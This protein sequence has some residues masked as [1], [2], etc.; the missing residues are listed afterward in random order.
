[1]QTFNKFEAPLYFGTKFVKLW[2]IKKKIIIIS[3]NYFMLK[4]NNIKLETKFFNCVLVSWKEKAY[5]HIHTKQKKAR[6]HVKHKS[7]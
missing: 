2:Y 6:K 3:I 1:M 4:K 5:R 7:T